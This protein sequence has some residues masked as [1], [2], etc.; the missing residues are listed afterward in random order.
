M[1]FNASSLT[2]TEAFSVLSMLRVG[3]CTRSW[4]MMSSEVIARHLWVGRQLAVAQLY[5]LPRTWR[6]HRHEPLQEQAVSEEELDV[7]VC[8]STDSGP[9]S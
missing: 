7:N 6:Q 1:I 3:V 9:T 4:H 2:P 8:R 5:G